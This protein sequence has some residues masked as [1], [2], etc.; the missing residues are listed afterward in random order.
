MTSLELPLLLA[1][2]FH[3]SQWV[4]QHSDYFHGPSLDLP[5]QGAI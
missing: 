2:K 1:I 3:L 5:G 4:F